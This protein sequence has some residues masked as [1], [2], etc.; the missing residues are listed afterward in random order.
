MKQLMGLPFLPSTH[1]ADVFRLMKE[2]C[3]PQKLVDYVDRQWMENATFPIHSWSV[4]NSRP[5]PT[6]SEVLVFV[7]KNLFKWDDNLQIQYET[8]D[9]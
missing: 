1:I 2:K 4:S 3:P 7:F 8:F 6:I 9:M 5:G